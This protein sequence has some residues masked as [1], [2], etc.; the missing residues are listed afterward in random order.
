MKISGAKYL[1]EGSSLLQ[2]EYYR[3]SVSVEPVHPVCQE[4]IVGI[5]EQ[6]VAG[7]RYVL[8]LDHLTDGS[9]IIEDCDDGL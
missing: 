3:I 1:P 9:A 6:L 5:T 7:V 2:C 4:M 8:H